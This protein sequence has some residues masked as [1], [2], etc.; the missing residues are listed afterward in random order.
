V[1]KNAGSL[2]GKILLDCTNPLRPDLSGLTVGEDS[3]GGEMVAGWAPGAKVFKVFNQTGFNIM[4]DPVVDGRKSL[5]LVCGDDEAT[6]P[7][8]MGIVE[9]VGFEAVDFGNLSGARLLESL[10]LTWIRLAYQCELGRD[11][12]FGLLRR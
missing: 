5:M 1:L 7:T 6:K 10:A 3:S 11:F 12:A 8:V 4:A 9:D 2:K